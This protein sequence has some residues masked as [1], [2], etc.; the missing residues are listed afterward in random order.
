MKFIFL[1]LEN[2]DTIFDCLSLFMQY[3]TTLYKAWRMHNFKQNYTQHGNCIITLYCLYILNLTD[4][5]FGFKAENLTGM[6]W[7]FHFMYTVNIQYCHR[8]SLFHFC[9]IKPNANY[10]VIIH[11]NFMYISICD[12]LVECKILIL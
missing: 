6:L 11:I 2:Y 4:E 9:I 7:Q 5:M 12:N 8:S 1:V 3:Y 10:L